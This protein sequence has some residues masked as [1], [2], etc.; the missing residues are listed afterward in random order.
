MANHARKHRFS[1][2]IEVSDPEMIERITELKRQ[3]ELRP[4]VHQLLE[5]YV[6]NEDDLNTFRLQLNQDGSLERIQQDIMIFQS[7]LD[8]VGVDLTNNFNEVLDKIGK[9]DFVK[10]KKAYTEFTG[11][12]V[13]DFNIDE[14]VSVDVS[15]KDIDER[16]SVLDSRLS[17]MESSIMGVL[18]EI[19]SKLSN[20][21]SGVVGVEPTINPTINPSVSTP[22]LNVGVEKVEDVLET[23]GD[24]EDSLSILGNLQ[25]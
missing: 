10:Y 24:L 14:V 16:I 3:R 21:S 25:L 15:S 19:T 7:F 1:F 9:G 8:S 11:T 12:S 13:E 6:Y 20:N 18:S 17:A 2:D 5:L 23:D 4:L 22:I